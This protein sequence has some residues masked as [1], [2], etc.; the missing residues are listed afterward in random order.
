MSNLKEA[1]SELRK[2]AEGEQDDAKHAANMQQA[3]ESGALQG[4]V[5]AVSTELERVLAAPNLEKERPALAA[6]HGFMKGFAKKRD[7]MVEGGRVDAVDAES[8]LSEFVEFTEGVYAFT[9]AVAAKPE[10]A[11]LKGSLDNMLWGLE[12][13]L[14]S[15][16]SRQA[17]R[18]A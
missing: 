16:R 15:L 5:N 1:L 2:L 7:K 4:V 14:E 13:K 9:K 8:I 12:K 10:A 17:G 11:P 3:R 6:L 18:K